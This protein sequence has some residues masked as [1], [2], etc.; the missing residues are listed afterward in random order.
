MGL[1]SV[2]LI[3][4]VEE[5]FGIAIDDAE[6]SL[7]ETVGDLEQVV[8]CKLA[9]QESKVTQAILAMNFGR[10]AAERK[11]WSEQEVW[12]ALQATLVDQLGVERDAVTR[13]ARIVQDL[14]V[15]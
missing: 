9:P 14:G 7:I 4:A 8:L 13:K 6:A 12:H 3:I 2:E 10:I 15:D 5:R 11:A 1:D